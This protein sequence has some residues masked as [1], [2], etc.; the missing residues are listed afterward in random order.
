VAIVNDATGTVSFAAEIEHRGDKIKAALDSRRAVRRN[1]R[2]RQTRYRKARFNN[3]TRTAGWLP[4]SLE[5]RIANIL[6]WV[7][8]LQRYCPITAISQELVKFDTQILQN[9]EISGIEYQQG[10]L[11]GYELREYLLEVRFVGQKLNLFRS[12]EDWPQVIS[13]SYN[14]RT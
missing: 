7:N 1:R 11:A 9:P 10:E 2:N 13:S 8:R 5:S 14:L 3:R 12:L 4:P 6:T